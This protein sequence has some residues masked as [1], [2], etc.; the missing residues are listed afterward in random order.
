MMDYLLCRTQLWPKMK[1]EK[2]DE[3]AVRKTFYQRQH[4]GIL[5]AHAHK[6]QEFEWSAPFVILSALQVS[7]LRF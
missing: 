7:D 4:M 1:R 3:Y 5:S 2:E 6:E